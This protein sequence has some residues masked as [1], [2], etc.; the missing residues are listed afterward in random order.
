VRTLP[1][2]DYH[3]LSVHEAERRTIFGREW[4][5]LGLAAG[6]AEPG[7]F[8]AETVAGWPLVVVRDREGTLRAFH[9]VCRHRA[10][11]L[12]TDAAGSRPSLV[13]RY[14]GWSYGLDGSL[15]AARDSGLGGDDLCGLDLLAVRVEVWRG[16]LFACLDPSARPLTEWLDGFA[17]ACSGYPMEQWTPGP[18]RTHAIGANWKAYGDNYL[19]GYHVPLVHPGLNRAID[20]STYRV[21]VFDGWARHHAEPRD[22]SRSTGTWL[23][24]W[25]NLALN[26]YEGGM[27]VERWHPTS[28]TSCELVLDH[29]YNASDPGGAEQCR[30]DVAASD[31]ICAEDKAICEAV[32]HN[33][34]AGAYDTGLLSPRH[35]QGVADFQRRVLTARA[36]SNLAKR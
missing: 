35:E 17:D 8:V 21:D 18:R 5:P 14:H 32:Q 16:L 28:P 2:T 13:C 29:A 7:T 23:W 1:A 3:D 12:V 33:L 6:V 36:D 15:L 4:L 27:S 11:P 31:V 26:L 10:G 24:H 22:G 20:S 34:S 30:Q 9:N 25:P 19:E